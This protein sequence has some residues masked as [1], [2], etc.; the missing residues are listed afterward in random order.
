MELSLGKTLT[1]AAHT[2]SSGTAAGGPDGIFDSSL[3]IAGGSYS[4]TLDD[5]GTY[6]Y[7]CMVHPWMQGT[8]IVEAEAAHGDEDDGVTWKKKDMVMTTLQSGIEDLSDK[9][10][11]SVT[12]GEIHHIGANY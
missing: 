12:S 5:E 1:H 3:I 4:V 9:F 7:F 10:T 11:A 2:A 8:V 6:P